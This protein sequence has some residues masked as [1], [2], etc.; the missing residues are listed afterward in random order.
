MADLNDEDNIQ[1][2]L[3]C[4]CERIW[5]SD[6]VGGFYDRYLVPLI[7]FVFYMSASGYGGRAHYQR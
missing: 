5:T 4:R 1:I 2:F 7:L 3:F 6:L